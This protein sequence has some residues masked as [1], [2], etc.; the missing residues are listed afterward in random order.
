MGKFNHPA[1]KTNKI[2]S[3]LGTFSIL[4]TI[5]LT[6]TTCK[7]KSPSEEITSQPTYTNGQGII[8]PNGGTVLINDASSP[9]NGAYIFIPQG[10]LD[11]NIEIKI[12][13]AIAGD[14]FIA[15][16]SKL[17]VK[18]EPENLLF[19]TPVKIGIPYQN[20]SDTSNLNIFYYRPDSVVSQIPKYYTDAKN[21]VVYGE[22]NHFSY[23][24]VWDGNR[25]MNV[26]MLNVDGK[27]GARLYIDDF[28]QFR[29]RVIYMLATG[30]LE[31]W[32]ALK[33]D[34]GSINSAFWVSLYKSGY[35]W[36]HYETRLVL[37]VNRGSASKSTGNYF[38][39]VFKPLDA[40]PR[41]TTGTLDDDG[42]KRWFGG[43][44]LVFYFDGYTPDP[45]AK[46]YVKIEWALGT[47]LNTGDADFTYTPIFDFLNEA[48]KSK[49]SQMTSF[50][51]SNL[52]NTYIDKSYVNGNGYATVVTSSATNI[53]QN[54]AVLGGNVVSDGGATVTD[55][56]VCWGTAINPTTSNNSQSMGSGTGQFSSVVSTFQSNTQ[57]WVRAYASNSVGTSYGGNIIVKTTS[58]TDL[59]PNPPSN[60]SPA[61]NATNVSTSTSLSWTC[62]DPENDPLKFDVYFGTS[63]NPPLVSSNQSQFT[64]DPTSLSSSTL[65]YWKIV[66]KDDHGNSTPGTIWSFT[67]GSGLNNPPNQP[68]NPNPANNMMNVSPYT[69]LSW[70][71]T[72]PENDPLTFNVYF[73]TS[74]NPPLVSTGQSQNNYTPTSLSYGTVYYWKIEANDDHGNSTQ[75]IVWTF[76]TVGLDGQPCPEIPTYTDPRDGQIYPTVKQGFQCWLQKNMN[77]STGNWCC[78]ENNASNCETY[79][80]LYDWGSSLTVCPSGWH[81]PSDGEWCTLT[82]H[83]DPTVNCNNTNELGTMAGYAMKSTSGWYNNGNGNNV[84]EFTGLP[85]GM[86]YDTGTFQGL[87]EETG[88]W[89]S[90][91]SS[92]N[93]AY[94]WMLR[95]DFN[96]V[97][98][99]NEYKTRFYSVRCVKD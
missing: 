63:S 69:S 86:R 1:M 10:A 27:I 73:G 16:S 68:S 9:L 88:F 40:T 79:G 70:T 33:G 23:Y 29:T 42:I 78:Y 6:L 53:T 93:Y 15:D 96:E 43:K 47:L 48:N 59:P 92:S 95:S 55:R 44:P 14:K 71:C 46:Y 34:P 24:T 19:K 45:T 64:Y 30:F 61:N 41:Y 82:T 39:N 67:T 38:G 85:S 52:Y 60:P 66:V 51:S 7:K 28:Y 50:S 98:R 4:V 57:Y 3:L 8:G 11:N 36:D 75:G 20:T 13:G 37:Y 81:L 72:D 2:F 56:G 54:S 35:F 65:Y 87:T 58:V 90:T 80:K 31:V 5:I 83:L 26:E 84:S 77:F 91:E 18:F 97:L 22:T 74:N 49:I 12:S 62:T 99:I 32:D 25:N 94:N 76:I 21:K 17:L 89:S